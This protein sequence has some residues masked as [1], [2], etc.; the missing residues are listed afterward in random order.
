M[1]MNRQKS[2]KLG[3]GIVMIMLLGLSIS[4][5]VMRSTHYKSFA[6]LRKEAASSYT[7]QV[8]DSILSI[9]ER[10]ELPVFFAVES[11]MNYWIPTYTGVF[12]TSIPLSNTK[13]STI[14]PG[15][16][17]G[18]SMY[19]ILQYNDYGS[20]AMSRVTMLYGYLCFPIQFGDTALPNGSLFTIVD[21]A[22][23]PDRFLFY[24]RMKDG[25]Y[26]GV[27]QE[28]NDEFM[29]FAR[30]VTYWTQNDKPEPLDL[31]STAG[32]LYRFSIQYSSS[33][34]ELSNAII[35]QDN[36]KLAMDEAQK[37]VQLHQQKFDSLVREAQNPKSNSAMMPTLLQF[38]R[39]DLKEKEKGLGA[40]SAQ[41]M[42]NV[43][44]IT[45]K[46]EEL[47]ILIASF[48]GTLNKIKETDPDVATLDMQS[49][50]KI[51]NDPVEKILQGD[52][53]TLQKLGNLLPNPSSLDAHEPLDELYRE[54][55]ESLP[56]RYDPLNQAIQ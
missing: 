10:G 36:C 2:G 52:R 47:N 20:A 32:S 56:M 49:I 55:F 13:N 53:S 38:S 43:A 40:L 12:N 44:T 23:K 39:E 25:R 5:C 51:F 7:H 28:K 33:L 3:T 50:V 18:E 22:E 34:K 30:D 9:R 14:S 27:T 19:N 21:I 11:G 16:S 31:V 46:T 29:R 6:D 17:T 37:V 41:M 48:Q 42:T 1:I 54:R 24:S 45:A 4:G 26:M 15:L 8:L 35:S